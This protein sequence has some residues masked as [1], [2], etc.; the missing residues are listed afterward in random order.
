M[1]MCQK[2]IKLPWTQRLGVVLFIPAQKN[3]K[4]FMRTVFGTYS[5]YHK[6]YIE[7]PDASFL[8]TWCTCNIITVN[9]H[10]QSLASSILIMIWLF[11]R[12]KY[13]CL[14]SFFA[15]FL[16][17][18]M[19]QTVLRKLD[20]ARC[21]LSQYKDWWTLECRCVFFSDTLETARG[22]GYAPT[23][24]WYAVTSNCSIRSKL[25]WRRISK[26]CLQKPGVQQTVKKLGIWKRKNYRSH[27]T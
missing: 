9:I 20:R 6:S 21:L 10:Y 7:K 17:N 3:A 26:P 25:L 27:H 24:A 2:N 16:T 4:Y 13:R 18:F 19:R 8:L 11:C 5:L 15:Q 1:S 12:F 23:Q 22:S 14:S